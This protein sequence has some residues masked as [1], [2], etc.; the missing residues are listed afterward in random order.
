[1]GG[2]AD[3]S[4]RDEIIALLKHGGKFE[5]L[6][7]FH[8]GMNGYAFRATHIPLQREVFLK[9]CDADPTSAD[10]FQEPLSLVNATGSTGATNLVKLFDAEKLGQ[11]FVLM[12]MELADGGN[13]QSAVNSRLGQA[14]AV[15]FA[16]QILHGVSVLHSARLLHRDLKPANILIFEPTGRLILKVGDF[17]SVAAIPEGASSVPASRHSALYVPPEGWLNPSYYC[18]RSDLYQVG[19]ILHEMVNGPLPYEWPPYLDTLGKSCLASKGCS[20]ISEL[21]TFEG[22]ILVNEC[23]ARRS[24][25]RKLLSLRESAPYESKSLKRIIKKATSPSISDRYDSAIEFISALQGLSI[26]NWKPE[27]EDFVALNWKNWDWKVVT[28]SSGSACILR[29]RAGASNFRAWRASP[30][31][32]DAF[33]LVEEFV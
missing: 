2:V 20:T 9:V 15:R 14:D 33:R 27:G 6:E 10:F 5:I 26:P 18:A 24:G 12:A 3:L 28:E 4:S 21:D 16:I 17:G 30:T 22:T 13:L 1:L 32:A 29:R 23:I 11:S 19:M 8:G 31:E 7:E 25:M